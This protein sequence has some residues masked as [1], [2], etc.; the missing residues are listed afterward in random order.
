[1]MVDA[2]DGNQTGGPF[3]VKLNRVIM[4]I[5]ASSESHPSPLS[6]IVA[7]LQ[8][9]LKELNLIFLLPSLRTHTVF[10]NFQ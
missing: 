6:S 8:N 1:M 10:N 7:L 3:T 4:V 2:E 5:L 9:K